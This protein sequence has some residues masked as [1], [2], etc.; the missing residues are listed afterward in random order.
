MI[1]LHFVEEHWIKKCFC[2]V[3]KLCRHS[4]TIRFNCGLLH[5]QNSIKL[6]WFVEPGKLH[7]RLSAIIGHH[8]F[9]LPKVYTSSI[10]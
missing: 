6:H 8:S 9:R 1:S 5:D 7:T 3:I 4:D 2:T 10:I